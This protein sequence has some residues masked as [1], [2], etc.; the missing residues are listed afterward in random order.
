MSIPPNLTNYGGG[1]HGSSGGHGRTAH[2][3]SRRQKWRTNGRG[4]RR[5]KNFKKAVGS[6][7]E[8]WH[9]TALHTAGGLYRHQL[10]QNRHGRIVSR[11][12]SSQGR[13]RR[14]NNLPSHYFQPRGSG[15]FGPNK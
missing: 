13:N 7:A 15:V 12:K 9:N 11:R 14:S 8:V 5:R 10:T 6:R 3:G 1:T 4:S 2:G